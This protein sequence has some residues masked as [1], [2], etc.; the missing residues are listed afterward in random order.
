VNNENLTS[1]LHARY[2]DAMML[3]RLS[4]H[5]LH[6]CALHHFYISLR[7][8]RIKYRDHRDI[9]TPGISSLCIVL[10]DATVVTDLQ[11]TTY[12]KVKT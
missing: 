7:G 3:I 5:L 8:S 4:L 9:L 2:D 1:S 10:K 6:C 12:I 11:Y